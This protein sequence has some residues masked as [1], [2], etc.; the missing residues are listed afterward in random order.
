MFDEQRINFPT[1]YRYILKNIKRASV[2]FLNKISDHL[3]QSV[4]NDPDFKE[5]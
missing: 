4:D 1:K 5:N 3:E 2:N